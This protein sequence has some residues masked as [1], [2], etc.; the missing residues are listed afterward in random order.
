MH[1][2]SDMPKG[3]AKIVPS[4]E[5]D[6]FGPFRRP[7]RQSVP[8]ATLRQRS[9]LISRFGGGDRARPA[10]LP[11]AGPGNVEKGV[12]LLSHCPKFKVLPT[13][14]LEK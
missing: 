2:I 14:L 8:K 3:A 5:P 10:F 1:G 11:N 6:R 4:P 13:A 9:R 7:I 12:S